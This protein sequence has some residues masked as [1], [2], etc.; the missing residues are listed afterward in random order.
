MRG[1][2]R[3]NSKDLMEQDSPSAPAAA[4]GAV[5]RRFPIHPG[6][7]SRRSVRNAA[8]ARAHPKV[9]S[10]MRPTATTCWWMCRAWRS[11]ALA[12]Q[13][14][15]PDD[16]YIVRGFEGLRGIEGGQMPAQYGNSP[17]LICD[18]GQK[19]TVLS[20]TNRF[21]YSY[22][23]RCKQYIGMANTTIIANPSPITVTRSTPITIGSSDTLYASNGLNY[24]SSTESKAIL[25]SLLR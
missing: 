5:H 3:G 6:S 21:I 1:G 22:S 18:S 25:L 9:F 10:S 24:N 11:L 20:F 17:S 8:S 4:P 23:N 2:L 7:V 13:P 16:S 14:G 15:D 12:S 19:L